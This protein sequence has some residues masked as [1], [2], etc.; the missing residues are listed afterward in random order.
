MAQVGRA[1]AAA[2]AD[3]GLPT[4]W[5]GPDPLNKHLAT[6]REKWGEREGMHELWN[7]LSEFN[8]QDWGDSRN[9][10][11]Q[12]SKNTS[13]EKILHKVYKS[14]RNFTERNWN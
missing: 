12:E 13:C 10:E 2:V 1:T 7:Q 5:R 4:V 9:L 3:E 14:L 6:V 11:P 8:K